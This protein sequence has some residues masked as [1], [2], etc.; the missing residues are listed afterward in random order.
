MDPT[1]GRIVHYKCVDDGEIRPA[2]VTKVWTE[3]CVNLLVFLDG[4][5]D[6]GKGHTLSFTS[7]MRGNE[8]GQWQWPTIKAETAG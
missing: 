3:D 4:S 8:K 7:V 2:I 6:Y 5:L 1:V